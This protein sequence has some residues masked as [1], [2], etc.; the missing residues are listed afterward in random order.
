MGAPILSV[1]AIGLFKEVVEGRKKFGPNPCAVIVL[2]CVIEHRAASSHAVQH[3][4]EVADGETTT[5]AKQTTEE[6]T[7]LRIFE[8]SAATDLHE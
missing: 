7:E 8:S 4:I 5:I 2:G 1:V 3:S 6:L